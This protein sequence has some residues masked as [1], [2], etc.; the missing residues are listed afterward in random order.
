MLV[1]LDEMPTNLPPEAKAKWMKAMNAKTDEE[2]IAALEEFLSSIPKH[3]GTENL[4][5]FVRHRIAALRQE[6]ELKQKK[7]KGSR[8]GRTIYVEKEGDAQLGVVGLPSSGKSSLLKCLTNANVE[9]DDVPFTDSQ[10]IPGMFIEDLIY[11]QLVKFPSLNPF[12][13]ESDTNVLAASLARNVD[14]LIIVLDASSNIE[15]QVR[16]IEEIFKG[17]GI[18]IRQPRAL[19]S[20]KRTVSGGIQV[21][22]SFHG[23]SIDSVKRLLADYGILNAQVTIN[24]EATLDDVE[25]ALY[26]NYVYKPSIFL[27][28]K[29]DLIDRG[30]LAGIELE[31]RILASLVKCRINRKQLSETILRRLDLIRIYSKNTQMDTY[32]RKPLIMRR[33]STVG[34]VAKSIHTSLYENFRYARVWRMED[35]PNLYKK[36][37]LNYVLDDQNIIEIHS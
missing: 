6:I 36:V 24:G 7:E 20:I 28:N 1:P 37:G 4:V 21:S 26:K 5:H 25:D 17:H 23:C 14:G 12:D 27:I 18:L 34:D 8:G 33:G 9:P 11:Y 15:E 2:K 22:G 3:K 29:V 13:A 19:I 30:S 31:P 16:R 32:S 10:P 35:Y